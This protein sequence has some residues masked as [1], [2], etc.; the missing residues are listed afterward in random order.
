M[1]PRFPTYVIS[2][3]RT[4]LSELEA[5]QQPSNIVL[6]E[7]VTKLLRRDYDRD[8]PERR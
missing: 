8:H 4:L 3:L 5:G 6:D 1:D 7:V 2:E